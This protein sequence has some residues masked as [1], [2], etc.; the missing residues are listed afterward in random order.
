MLAPMQGLTNR[1]LRSLFI[2]W[3]RPD[4]VF[5]EFVQVRPGAERIIAKADAAE[6]AAHDSA[7]PLVVQLMGS[8]PE[9]LVAAAEAARDAGAGHLNIN[10][11][12]PY[13]RMTRNAAGGALLKD[14]ARL[15]ETL[16]G[17]REA[18]PGSLS[19]KLRSGHEEPC[20][21]FGLTPY[22]EEAGVDFL[23]LHPRTVVSKFD[24]PADHAITQRFCREC[25]LP[26]IANGDI[27]R[28]ADGERLLAE[29]AAAG[30]ML[31]RGAISDPW[32]FARLRGERPAEVD[33]A[34]RRAELREYLTAL[35]AR[36]VDLFSGD[37][38]VL[39]KL[40]EVV[41][42]IDDGWFT[43]PRKVLR[44]CK[45]LDRFLAEVASLL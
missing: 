39:F 44:K 42:Q 32:L 34:T 17:L 4:V 1:A 25:S 37:T 10:M 20:D 13:G 23:I 29:T 26:V 38:Q 40:K 30:L 12:C 2:E 3:V 28:A 43:K 15:P 31:G 6:I 7:V 11:G 16:A 45:R 24:G 35:A 41:N 14:P 27:F 8:D 9:G 19:V 22:F 5:T 18:T 36:Y 21:V 33:E